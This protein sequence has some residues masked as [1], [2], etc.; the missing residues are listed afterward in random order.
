MCIKLH[1]VCYGLATVVFFAHAAPGAAAGARVG[2][3]VAT[4]L[5]LGRG[6]CYGLVWA[7]VPDRDVAGEVM[8]A[9]V[10]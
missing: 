1:L 7:G 9:P 4:Q 5:V 10:S 6:A 2:A 8:V 3:D